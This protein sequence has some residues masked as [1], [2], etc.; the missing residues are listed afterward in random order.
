[1]DYPVMVLF[2]RTI[3]LIEMISKMI[4]MIKAVIDDVY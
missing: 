4:S 1:M 2:V 3:T